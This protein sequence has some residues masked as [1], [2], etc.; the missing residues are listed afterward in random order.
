MAS[1]KTILFISTGEHGQANIFFATAHE[2]L[3]LD[4][5]VELHY[6]SFPKLEKAVAATSEYAV[7]SAPHPVRPIVFHTLPGPSQIDA[8]I[9]NGMAGSIGN[10]FADPPDRSDRTRVVASLV[11]SFSSWLPEEY[12]EIYRAVETIIEKINPRI[13]VIDT[14]MGP[15][16][17]VVKHL[18][19][20]HAILTPQ[21]FKEFVG[22]NQPNG[23]VL[24]KYPFP[25]SGFPYPL[26]WSYIPAN[27]FYYVRMA[28]LMIKDRNIPNTTALVKSE[29]GAET[30]TS[31]EFFRPKP[32]DKPVRI[33][34]NARAETE[35]PLDLSPK[36][37]QNHLTGCGPIVMA[38][39]DVSDSDPE[40]AA[41]LA[42]GPTVFI[43]L[44]THLIYTEKMAMEMASALRL[45]FTRAEAAGMKNLQVLWKLKTPKAGATYD[46]ARDSAIAHE[47]SQGKVRITDWLVADPISILHSGHVV[48][49]VNHGGASSFNEPIVAGVP[50][51]ILPQWIDTY[52]FAYR[53][54]Y[55]GIGVWGSHKAAP[56][57]SADELGQALVEAVVS[58]K[59]AEM[60]A[61]VVELSKICNENGG[62]RMIA[63]KGILAAAE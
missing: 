53:V 33:F 8:M 55:L 4:P 36:L 37:C 39:P 19:A 15:A 41:W 61:R 27:I 7:R 31:T 60:K 21:T 59:A 50:Q 2:L 62:G 11:S 57:W 34:V 46:L 51:V 44:G 56:K 49:S 54:E 47:I 6:A 40:L 63:A 14:N 5:D 13:T 17:A 52:D 25:S 26:P 45:L 16:L 48:C 9:R 3:H 22:G 24:W 1:P 42:R 29:L 38:A 28:W 30:Y 10:I 35:L 43:C 58:E 23:E 12:V 32:T 18:G 20:N